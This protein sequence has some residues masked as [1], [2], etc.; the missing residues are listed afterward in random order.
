[1]RRKD[2]MAKLW[3]LCLVLLGVL[4]SGCTDKKPA[5]VLDTD[6]VPEESVSPTFTVPEP[7]TVYVEIFGSEFKPQELKII[8]GTTVR[9]TNKDSAVHTVK[10]EG[11]S[12]PPLNKREIWN[13][14]FNK[15]GAFEYS[16]SN[17]SLM[18]HG[19]IIVD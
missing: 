18:Q 2:L 4:L 6:Q 13:Y 19:R 9:W 15:S 8:K 10:G 11:F 5:Q 16:C 7:T 12:S 17:Q 3:L 14:T 1:M